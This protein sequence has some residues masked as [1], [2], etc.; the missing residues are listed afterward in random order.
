MHG[1]LKKSTALA[2]AVAA[3]VLT[4]ASSLFFD[5]V[6]DNAS[7]SSIGS[8]ALA[9]ACPLKSEAR[10]EEASD[11]LLFISCGGFLE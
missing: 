5:F 8:V 6:R 1:R 10:V 4:Y 2:L 9:S 7:A 11:P 3:P